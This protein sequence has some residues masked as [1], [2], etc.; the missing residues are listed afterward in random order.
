MKF[1]ESVAVRDFL[2]RV[3]W[4]FSLCAPGAFSFVDPAALSNKVVSSV[5][6]TSVSAISRPT[7]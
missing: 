7:L 2:T 4:I 3:N 6:L 1:V 5:E